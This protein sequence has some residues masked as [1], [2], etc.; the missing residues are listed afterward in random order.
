MKISRGFSSEP[1][2]HAFTKESLHSWTTDVFQKLGIP[3]DDAI[4]ASDVLSKS[5]IRG[6]DSHGVGKSHSSWFAI[7]SPK[8]EWKL[9]MNY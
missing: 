4:L 6:I 2:A 5:D 1:K 7:K 8:Q 3:K 9:I